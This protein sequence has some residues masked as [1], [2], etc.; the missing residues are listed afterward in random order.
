M[1]FIIISMKQNLSRSNKNPKL[2][3]P[4][5]YK[6]KWTITVVTYSQILNAQT[7]NLVFSTHLSAHL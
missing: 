7:E 2:H 5:I 1:P 6:F 4:H 3:G